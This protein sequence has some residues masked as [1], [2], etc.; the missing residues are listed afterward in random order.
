MYLALPVPGDGRRGE[1]R[2]VRLVR[3]A[4]AALVIW[5]AAV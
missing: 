5:T 4:A 3:P 2:G 1:E